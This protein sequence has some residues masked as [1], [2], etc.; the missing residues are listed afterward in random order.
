MQMKLRGLLTGC[1]PQGT[2]AASFLVVVAPWAS[3]PG[4]KTTHCAYKASVEKKSK[5]GSQ[6]EKDLLQEEREKLALE[7]NQRSPFTANPSHTLS[8]GN[9]ALEGGGLS[10]SLA[11][12][13][14]LVV[15]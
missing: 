8:M 11:R 10:L 4:M 13:W 9:W 14:G 7:R 6:A 3:K 15:T 12:S 1:H 5:P 2:E